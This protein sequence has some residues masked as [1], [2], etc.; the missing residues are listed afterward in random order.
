MQFV[1]GIFNTIVEF[2]KNIGNVLNLEYM[3]YA[4][5][6]VEV[7]MVIIFSIMASQVYEIKLLRAV[8]K[9]N[10][11]L[12]H[13]PYIEETNLIEF[14][15][16]MKKVPKVLRYHWQQ[17]MLYREKS[18]SYYMSIENCI[19]IP[20]KSSFFE[21]IIRVVRSF[22][23]IIAAVALVLACGR[24]SGVDGASFYVSAFATPA[25]VLLIN[26]VFTMALQIKK[27]SN[28]SD[29][30]QTFHIFNRFI[31]KA[32]TTLPEYVDYEVLFTRAEIKKGIPVLNEYIEK[33]QI[34]EQEEMK[35][36]RLNAVEHVPYNFD[37]VGEKGSLVLERAMKET[38]TF[39][40]MRY[41]LNAEIEQ[42]ENE[43]EGV[44]RSYD[45]KSKEYQRNLQTVKENIDRLKE[46]IESSTN[47]VATNYIRKQQTDE[48]KKKD[49]LENDQQDATMRFNQEINALTEEIDKRKQEL[50]EGRQYVEK[51]MLAE[52]KTFADKTFKEIREKVN[53]INKDEKQGLEDSIQKITAELE[54]ALSE[55]ERLEKEN[56]DLKEQLNLDNAE[57]LQEDKQKKEEEREQ[58]A[59]E[60]L[61]KK[62]KGDEPEYDEFGGYYD[63]EGYYRYA[64]GTYYDPEGNFHDEFG[65]IV[66]V[67]G[68]Y[69]EPETS[70]EAVEPALEVE[71]AP[72]EE[73]AVEIK[74]QAEKKLATKKATKKKKPAVKKA[75]NKKKKEVKTAK[76][77]TKR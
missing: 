7:L 37:S 28:L 22:G 67:N 46:E 34:Q 25:I 27:S 59:A 54:T 19:D 17:F 48:I 2:F 26:G 71:E 57:I 74:P 62:I 4:F 8:D 47:R 30:Y 35:K 56:K 32:V 76:P 11:Y 1:L 6:G 42:L 40:N 53:Q 52:Y 24:L 65:G 75:T 61:N 58:K 20:L 31:D 15:N 43:M 72:K 10:A 63:E 3:L 70:Q 50:E 77:E 49:K 64:N 33:R 41:R 68:N 69:I 39:I 12:Y 51:S 66:D 55:V 38:E 16:K 45:N 18:P 14:N 23:I 60:L 44:K 13:N 5:V 73:P 29:L 21:S 9:I 36:A